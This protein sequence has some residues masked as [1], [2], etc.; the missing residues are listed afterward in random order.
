MWRWLRSGPEECDDDN[1]NDNDS[2]LSTCQWNGCGDGIR[3]M[4]VTNTTNPAAIEACD[5]GNGIETDA[6]TDG[7]SWNGCGD[8]AAYTDDDAFT[9]GT[10]YGGQVCD[11]DIDRD[12]NAMNEPLG[13]YCDAIGVSPMDECVNF[14]DT[15]ECDDGNAEETDSCLASCEFNSCGDGTPY[16]LRTNAENENA[17]EQCD[18]GVASATCTGVVGPNVPA[19]DECKLITCGDGVISPTGGETCDPEHADWQDLEEGCTACRV[20]TCGNGNDNDDGDFAECDDGNTVNDDGCTNDCFEP[21]CGD[22]IVQDDEDCD[23]GNTDPTDTCTNACEEAD[24]GDGIRQGDE[25]CDYGTASMTANGVLNDDGFADTSGY[26][27]NTCEVQCFPSPSRAWAKESEEETCVFIPEPLNDATG[28]V[29]HEY[30]LAT[31]VEAEAYCD[32]LGIDAH[33]VKVA[34]ESKNDFVYDLVAAS[35]AGD[36]TATL[37]QYCADGTRDLVG[38]GPDNDG[39]LPELCN[40]ETEDPTIPDPADAAVDCV[41]PGDCTD[42]AATCVGTAPGV[43]TIPNPAYVADNDTVAC[44]TNNDGGDPALCCTILTDAPYWIGLYDNH[45]T[46]IDPPGRWIWIGDETAVSGNG[47]NSLWESGFPND[48]DNDTETAGQADCGAM[49]GADNMGTTG[50]WNDLPCNAQLRFVCEFPLEQSP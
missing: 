5:D 49:I 24:C 7:C 48:I 21:R 3:Y 13:D 4:A 28:T 26:C 8:G 40:P 43:C 30:G 47:G 50:E 45:T 34:D 1:A 35:L 37:P 46:Q 42:L 38:C 33:L 27:S 14:N 17:L 41:D 11:I 29:F 22:G 15:E 20:D 31:F 32:G 9:C 23:D 6:C 18:D 36:D 10:G 16:L 44:G 39:G 2:C 25:E 12:G 19:G